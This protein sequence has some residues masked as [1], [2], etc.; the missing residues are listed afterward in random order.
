MGLAGG[1]PGL[2]WRN[3]TILSPILLPLQRSPLKPPAQARW[4]SGRVDLSNK[5]YE[6]IA[7]LGSTA[8][9][10]QSEACPPP[11]P[12]KNPSRTMVQGRAGHAS[13]GMASHLEKCSPY[14]SRTVCRV[15]AR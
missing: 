11:L 5:T 1:G 4:A 13:G 15:L 12:I 3:Q 8:P 2:N 14:R 9:Q 7:N 6:T 10:S